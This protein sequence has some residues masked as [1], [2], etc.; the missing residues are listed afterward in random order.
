MTYRLLAATALSLTL[1]ACASSSPRKGDRPKSN[2]EE[3]GGTKVATPMALALSGMVSGPDGSIDL[4]VIDSAAADMFDLFDGDGSETLS[5]IEHARW[6]GAI[7][8]DAYARPTLRMI[9]TNHDGLA[10]RQEFVETIQ[11]EARRL[12]ADADGILMRTELLKEI[13]QSR[14]GGQAG[15]QRSGG[16]GQGQGRGPRRQ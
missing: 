3:M 4:S 6:A 5:R 16:N 13:P 10:T 14:R 11:A 7:L 1:V 15:G 8:G 9:D 2:T 12:D